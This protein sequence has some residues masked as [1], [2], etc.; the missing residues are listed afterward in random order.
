MKYRV[1]HLVSPSNR[2][3]IKRKIIESAP[4]RT[5]NEIKYFRST[6]YLNLYTAKCKIAIRISWK[7]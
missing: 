7:A 6:K 5:V 2:S 1:S 3:P 4:Y